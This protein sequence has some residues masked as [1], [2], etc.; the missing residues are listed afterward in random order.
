MHILQDLLCAGKDKVFHWTKAELIAP[1]K[2]RIY[3][4]KG[5]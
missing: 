4:P 2:I 1:N 3:A 5:Q